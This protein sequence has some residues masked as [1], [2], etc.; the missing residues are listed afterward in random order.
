MKGRCLVLCRDKGGNVFTDIYDGLAARGWALTIPGFREDA[1]DTG[2]LWRRLGVAMAGRRRAIRTLARGARRARVEFRFATDASGWFRDL[3]S[4]L[5]EPWDVVLASTGQLPI[6]A[7][8]LISRSHPRVVV[9]NMVTLQR[10]LGYARWLGA[11]RGVARLVHGSSMHPDAMREVD[12]RTLRTV[13]CPSTV[14]RDE[15]VAAGVPADVCRV[16]PIGVPI[17]DAVIPRRALDSPARLL[18]AARLSPEK[19]LHLFLAALPLVRRERAVTLTAVALEGPS[20][21]RESIAH[22]LATLGLDDI[23]RVQPSMPRPE[24]IRAFDDHD[25]LLFHSVF[26]EPVAQV[27]L[28]A[29]AA[30][31]PMVGPAS[32]RP[33]S[34]LNAHTAWCYDDTSPE[35]IA[36]AVLGALADDETRL[37]RAARLRDVVRDGHSFQHTVD[38]FDA[39]L[40]AVAAGGS[41]EGAGPAHGDLL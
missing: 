34:V 27:M 41:R 12:V 28:H 20:G 10:E 6:G 25:L 21:Y 31:L 38:E 36:A 15:A 29:A 8:R 26:G 30:G 19:G 3:E 1:D 18:W 5:R 17:P 9:L 22:Q 13:V 39:L 33:E 14:W 40:T 11:L 24:L 4:L 7:T 23:V 37:A 32:E 16:I 35:R 2:W